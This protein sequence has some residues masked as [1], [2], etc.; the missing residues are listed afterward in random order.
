[1]SSNTPHP[2]FHCVLCFM[3]NLA[4]KNINIAPVITNILFPKFTAWSSYH[5]A[6]RKRNR[7]EIIWKPSSWVLILF[8]PLLKTWFDHIYGQH[9]CKH[10]HT[11]KH[12]L[13]NFSFLI[14][15]TEGGSSINIIF[16]RFI[17]IVA[18]TC[19]SFIFLLWIIPLFEYSLIYLSVLIH[20]QS[21]L[22]FCFPKQC[23][24]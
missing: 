2:L 6:S 3:A 19:G 23:C 7:N 13:S 16:V 11:Y 12:T 8:F 21:L 9:I 17:Y 18:P 14:F 22:C 1:M 15:G 5:Q 10:I 24:L 20:L 4:N